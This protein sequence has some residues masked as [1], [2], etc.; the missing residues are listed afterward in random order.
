MASLTESNDPRNGQHYGMS[1]S[2]KGNRGSGTGN[3]RKRENLVLLFPVPETLF[4]K[5]CTRNPVPETGL[6][7]EIG[8]HAS[9]NQRKWNAL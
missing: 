9:R 5:P 3:S 4:P 6:G 2:Q 7:V 8:E 1:F